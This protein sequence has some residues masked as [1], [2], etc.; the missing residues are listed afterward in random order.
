MHFHDV[1]FSYMRFLGLWGWHVPDW[2]RCSQMHSQVSSQWKPS[3][4][5]TQLALV[6]LQMTDYKRDSLLKGQ[7]LLGAEDSW[8]KKRELSCHSKVLLN[9]SPWHAVP[10]WLLAGKGEA[11]PQRSWCFRRIE[12][13]GA[14][15]LALLTGSLLGT[16]MLGCR[17]S[18]F[19]A[20]QD[21]GCQWLAGRAALRRG[22]CAFAPLLSLLGM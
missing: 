6:R 18:C 3:K 10:T 9:I 1:A 5:C 16:D 22:N 20:G 7:G 11:P 12:P 21:G 2:S 15:L 4:A 14:E 17:G 8:E 19:P 13:Q